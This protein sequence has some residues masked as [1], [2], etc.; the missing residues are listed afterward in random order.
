VHHMPETHRPTLSPRRARRPRCSVCQSRAEIHRIAKARDG[1]E[2]WTLRC[3]KC[4]H[5][6]QVQVN[7]DPLKSEASGLFD[8]E[9]RPPK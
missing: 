5:I 8:S 3:T 7:V 9:L 2:H 6:D 1:F 4:G